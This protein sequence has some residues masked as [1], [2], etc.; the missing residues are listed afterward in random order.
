SS[1]FMAKVSACGA[2]ALLSRRAC[3]SQLSMTRPMRRRGGAD[4]GAGS[5]NERDIDEARIHAAGAEGLAGLDGGYDNR[6]RA[7]QH[8]VDRVANAFAALYVLAA[9]AARIR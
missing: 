6:S 7:E 9:R 3:Q 5:L 4:V 8:R 1:S 2:S